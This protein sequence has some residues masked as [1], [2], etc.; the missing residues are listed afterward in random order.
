MKGNLGHLLLEPKLRPSQFG[1]DGTA[2]CIRGLG[3]VLQIVYSNP[4]RLDYGSYTIQSVTLNGEKVQAAQS[5]AGVA[6]LIAACC[7]RYPMTS[8]NGFLSSLPDTRAYNISEALAGNSA[9][10]SSS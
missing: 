5:E 3:K 9:G 2:C 4:K 6:E 7:P 1:A 8:V 10:A